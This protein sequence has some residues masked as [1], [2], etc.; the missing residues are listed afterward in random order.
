A[1]TTATEWLDLDL[2]MAQ[3][4]A[5]FVLMQRQPVP[6]GA[7]ADCLGVGMSGGSHLVDR[8]VQDELVERS[9]DPDNRRRTLI[10]LTPAAEALVTRLQQGRV[11][12]LRRCL[13]RMEQ[14]DLQML[15]TGLR[16]LDAAARSGEDEERAAS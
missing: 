13:R 11:E 8:L 1:R 3:V 15:L 9:E 6:I 10:R 5:L 16:A 14:D 2:S 7:L 12:Q 4:K